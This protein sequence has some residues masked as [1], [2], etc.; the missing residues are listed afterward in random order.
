MSD[1]SI[2]DIGAKK[3]IVSPKSKHSPR[4]LFKKLSAD[5]K[6]AVFGMKKIKLS[7]NANFKNNHIIIPTYLN[8]KPSGK[9]NQPKLS[10]GKGT[11]QKSVRDKKLS[12]TIPKITYNSIV[13]SKK[14][15]LINPNRQKRSLRNKKK[16]TKN[17]TISIKLT[18]KNDI[19]K[20]KDIIEIINKF[21]KMDVKEIKDFL[22][23]KGIDSKRK[24]KSELL[25]YI[26]LLT[27]VDNDINIIK[28]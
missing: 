5:K 1:Y 10:P 22:K 8:N 26:Y 9:S 16:S 28:K 21:K 20:E 25:S 17:K 4:K 3:K 27:C 2:L 15:N 13:A 23:E 14:K 18:S 12:S 19:K 11:N 7:P 24:N 6:P